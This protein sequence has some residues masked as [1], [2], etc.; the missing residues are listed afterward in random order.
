MET[1]I[2]TFP[3]V[4]RAFSILLVETVK[5]SIMKVHMLNSVTPIMASCCIIA[6]SKRNYFDEYKSVMW[7]APETGRC[8][9]RSGQLTRSLLLKP[10]LIDCKD[11]FSPLLRPTRS[12]QA[13]GARLQSAIL[14]VLPK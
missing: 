4:P 6:T 7:G 11:H 13:R 2:V 14:P 12:Q 5:S 8:S 10:R 3:S 9:H 1:I